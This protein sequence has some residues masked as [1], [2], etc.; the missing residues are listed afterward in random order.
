MN[1]LEYFFKLTLFFSA[2]LF[3]MAVLLAYL[4]FSLRRAREE[5]EESDEYI[6]IAM[7]SREAERRRIAGELHDSALNSLRALEFTLSRRDSGTVAGSAGNAG[8]AAILET[9]RIRD[10]LRA[11]CESLL[12][13]DF[14]KLTLKNALTALCAAFSARTDLPCNF[15]CDEDVSTGVLDSATQLSFY[16]I[17][18]EALS[19]IEKHAGPSTVRVVFRNRAVRGFATLLLCVS[20]DGVG[21]GGKAPAAGGHF[22]VRMMRERARL[23]GADLNIVSEEGN[24]TMISI[25][26]FI[27]PPPPRKPR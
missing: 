8:H 11:L 15:S 6:R 16:R 9:R 10:E 18:Q 17:A 4:I 3:V 5:A 19:N 2:I 22:G 20:D 27:Y 23:M 7:L 25:E 14:E 24:G 26:A 12:P 1:E 21:L 13:P